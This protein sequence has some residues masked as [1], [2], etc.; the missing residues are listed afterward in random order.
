LGGL[1]TIWG[2][3]PRP[4]RGTATDYHDI[5]KMFSWVGGWRVA[6]SARAAAVKSRYVI[7]PDQPRTADG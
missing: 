6:R 5:N 4:E 1:V 2:L 3:C 7:Q